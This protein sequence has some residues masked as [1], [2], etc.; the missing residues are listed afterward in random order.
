MTRTPVLNTL[1]IVVVILCFALWLP[2]VTLA[3]ITSAVMLCIFSLVNLS[4]IREKLRQSDTPPFV[5]PM[6]VP[7]AGLLSCLSILL[8]QF[9][10]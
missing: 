4:L 5:V 2:I 9:F 3:K 7:V 6:A 8:Y 1:L 10:S